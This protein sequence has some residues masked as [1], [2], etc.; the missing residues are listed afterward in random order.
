MTQMAII[1]RYPRDHRAR[2]R[3]GKSPEPGAGAIKLCTDPPRKT[4]H[5]LL[6]PSE[7]HRPLDRRAGTD[8]R[9]TADADVVPGRG[10]VPHEV[11]ENRGD[12]RMVLRRVEAADGGAIDEQ[13]ARV[14]VLQAKEDVGKSGLACFIMFYDQPLG[15]MDSDGWSLPLPL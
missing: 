5:E 8:V 10:F 15:G 2:Q 13:L 1:V 9:D 11:L 14:E 3:R 7:R 6:G 4:V 12:V